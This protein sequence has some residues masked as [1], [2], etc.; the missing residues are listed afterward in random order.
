MNQ[1]KPTFLYI[2]QHKI[3]GLLYFGKT[4]KNP[5]KYHGSGVYWLRHIKQHGT[6]YVENIWYCLFL[7]EQECKD[8]AINFSVQ[9]DIV[10]SE[11]WANFIVEDGMSPTNCIGRKM[12]AETKAKIAKANTG[13]TFSEDTNK[14]K[15]SPG[16]KNPMYGVHRVGEQSPHFGK[17]HSEITK[18]ILSEKAKAREKIQCPH[19]LRVLD[20]ANAFKWH[21]DKCK[22]F[23]S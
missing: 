10:A 15:G 22:S 18:Q 21:F 7:A 12:S 4:T 14:R 9:N 2:K 23:V 19:C 1:F 6:K 11:L 3:T 5:E 8:F 20:K 17:P 16:S 13:K